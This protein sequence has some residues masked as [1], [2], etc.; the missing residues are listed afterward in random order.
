MNYKQEMITHLIHALS[1]LE[2]ELS[3]PKMPEK[4]RAWVHHVSLSLE[5]VNMQDEL[6]IWK[7]SISIW[8]SRYDEVIIQSPSL[9]QISSAKATL[10]GFLNNLS[11]EEQPSKSLF[12]MEIFQ[13]TRDYVYR[14]AEQVNICYNNGCYDAC[15]VMLRQ[16]LETLII[17]CFEHHAIASKIK[18]SNH[19]YINL[20]DMIKTF[21]N[22]STFNLSRETK[23][24]LS[25]LKAMGDKSAHNLYHTASRNDFDSL[26]QEITIILREL[27]SKSNVKK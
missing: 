20:D 6:K 7:E 11:N 2:K 15:A 26:A 27:L 24:N 5:S 4:F 3:S 12:S 8:H 10:L 19:N 1:L 22:E 23:N 18:G 17:Q 9:T 21:I 25:K 16:L 14:I 13:D